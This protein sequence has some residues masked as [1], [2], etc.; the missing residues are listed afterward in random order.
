[1]DEFIAG[2]GVIIIALLALLAIA[3]D[4]SADY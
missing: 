3:L 4:S 2:G 1:M